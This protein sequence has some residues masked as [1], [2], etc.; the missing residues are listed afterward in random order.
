MPCKH[1][2]EVLAA[3]RPVGLE[4]EKPWPVWAPEPC[5]E[6]Y[7]PIVPVSVHLCWLNSAA[8]MVYYR[9]LE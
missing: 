3:E 8:N 9:P 7:K 5:W 1:S 2:A 4:M 6:V